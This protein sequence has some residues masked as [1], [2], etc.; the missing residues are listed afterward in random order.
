MVIGTDG[1]VRYVDGMAEIGIQEGVSYCWGSGTRVVWSLART[2]AGFLVL[3]LASRIRLRLREGTRWDLWAYWY[4]GVRGLFGVA[5]LFSHDVVDLVLEMSFRFEVCWCIYWR[6]IWYGYLGVIGRNL[7]PREFDTW[8]SIHQIILFYLVTKWVLGGE[9]FGS[10]PIAKR[11]SNGWHHK[12]VALGLA[13]EG[14]FATVSSCQLASQPYGRCDSAVLRPSMIEEFVSFDKALMAN[15][16][17]VD[18]ARISRFLYV[19]EEMKY[20]RS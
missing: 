9:E 1:C 10:W 6:L 7:Y 18:L 17:I 8:P 15:L 13:S 20:L 5:E 19:S 4:H 3:C 16:C 11:I 12:S 2:W 14:F